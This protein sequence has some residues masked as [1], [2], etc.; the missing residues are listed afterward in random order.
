MSGARARV[1]LVAV[2]VA[3]ATLVLTQG[4]VMLHSCVDAGQFAP[5]GLQLALLRDAAQCPAGTYGLGPAS[6]G[7]VVLLSVGLPA[8]VAH[9]VLA[10]CGFGTWQVVRGC[11]RALAATGRRGLALPA[12]PAHVPAVR[13]VLV[14]VVLAPRGATRHVAMLTWSHRGPPLA[15]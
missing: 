9:L 15:A 14:P 6:T 10:A 11:V 7:A 4:R 3:V 1:P 5:F 8:L 12:A 13:R 2:L